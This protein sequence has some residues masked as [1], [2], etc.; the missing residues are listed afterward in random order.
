[1]GTVLQSPVHPHHHSADKRRWIP[2]G[3]ETQGILHQEV[4]FPA[5][6]NTV[7]GPDH[8]SVLPWIH[9][10]KNLKPYTFRQGVDQRVLSEGIRT[11]AW[12]LKEKKHKLLSPCSVTIHV[13]NIFLP[14]QNH[15]FLSGIV[16][17]KGSALHRPGSCS[18]KRA[19]AGP[20]AHRG[21]GT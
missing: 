11:S 20:G 15:P 5:H 6:S 16:Q 2:Q 9:K 17:N 19:S 8:A 13:T 12:G 21:E 1:M 4:K 18:H 3:Q 7:S 10:P 14:V